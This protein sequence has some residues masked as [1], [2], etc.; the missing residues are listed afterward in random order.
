MKLTLDLPGPVRVVATTDYKGN[1]LTVLLLGDIEVLHAEG[2]QPEGMDPSAWED[3]FRQRLARIFAGLLMG[4]DTHDETWH[5]QSPT[6]RE[7]YGRDSSAY[8]VRL[9]QESDEE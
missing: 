5:R 3:V 1:P 7:T 6:G 4:D 8:E 9:V 2:H